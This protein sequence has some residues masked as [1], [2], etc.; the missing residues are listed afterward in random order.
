MP[1]SPPR[2]SRW[3]QNGFHAF[4][5]PFLRRHF[6]TIAVDR[7][8]RESL[9]LTGEA[10]LV[11]FGNHPSWWDPLLAHF[12]CRR[13]FEGRQFYAPIDAAALEQYRVFGK[14]GFFGVDMHDRRG[15]AAF[16][17]TSLAVL[18]HPGSSLWITP[19]A[20]FTDVRD[21]SATF[22]PGLAHLCA[23]MPPGGIALPMALELVY[24]EERLPECL[25]RFGAPIRCDH[26]P[27]SDKTAWQQRLSDALHRTQDAL[28]ADTMARSPEPFE[29]LLSGGRGAGKLYD[30]FR[31]VRSLLRGRRFRSAHGEKFN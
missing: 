28:A 4:L 25:F 7:Q 22:A 10:P 3:L 14:L 18:N 21:R 31:H 17:K 27:E 26:Y 8:S 15:A 9:S 12:V 29:P 6:H 30:G 11:V 13:C 23:R 5:E 1:S 16:L 19:E 20:R 24:W 2:V